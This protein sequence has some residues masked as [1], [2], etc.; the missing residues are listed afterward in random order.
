MKSRAF[1]AGRPLRVRVLNGIGRVLRWMGFPP[2]R[3]SAKS[4]MAAAVRLA[5]TDEWGDDSFLE[6]LQVLLQSLREDSKLTYVGWFMLHEAIM[7]SLVNRLGIGQELRQRPEVLDEEIRR[8][9][10]VTGLPRSGTTMLQGLLATDPGNR[11]L[12][13]WEARYPVPAPTAET[14]DTDPRIAKAES[15]IHARRSLAPNLDAIHHMEAR[16]PAECRWLLMTTFAFPN[17]S[18]FANLPR[19]REWLDGQD[20]VPVYAYY[21][22]QLQ[23]LQSRFRRE[24]WLLKA[25]LHLHYLDSLLEVFPDACIVQNHRD[26][27]KAI[28]SLCSLVATVQGFTRTRVRPGRLGYGCLT[29]MARAVEHAAAVRESLNGQQFYDVQYKDLVSD[30]IRTVRGIYERFGYDYS[31]V[32][33]EGMHQWL[34]DNPQGKHGSHRYSLEQFN[35]DREQVMEHFSAYCERYGVSSQ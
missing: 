31:D 10:F 11:Y 2:G 29:E 30:P 34:A 23:L 5:G 7:R 22:R 4:L 32:F 28:P 15:S 14:S 17:F 1:M 12:R 18:I 26:P 33:E 16:A 20:M 25:P 8:P 9:L 35:L 19:Y 13:A 6:G 24:R 21:R 3:R 27:L